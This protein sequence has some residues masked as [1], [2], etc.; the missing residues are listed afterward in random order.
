[1]HEFFQILVLSKWS[2]YWNQTRISVCSL[3]QYF[4]YNWYLA[5]SYIIGPELYGVNPS[6]TVV[7][8]YRENKVDAMA[9]DVLCSWIETS[10]MLD[11]VK[12]LI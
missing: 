10:T 9:V 5:I 11:T 8:I 7:R 6:S 1:M 2:K 3:W 12:Y 4:T